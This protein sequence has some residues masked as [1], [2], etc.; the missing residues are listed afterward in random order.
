MALL[1]S[2]CGFHQSPR[3]HQAPSVCQ[4]HRAGT[5]TPT[6]ATD[7]A[8]TSTV[9]EADHETGTRAAAMVS[10]G[11]GT[12]PAA[13]AGGGVTQTPAA[14]M[15]G[16]AGRPAAAR[17]VAAGVRQRRGAGR[18]PGEISGAGQHNRAKPEVSWG[19]R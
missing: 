7:G 10:D 19:T 18:P 16:G 4:G 1:R 17:G 15:A 5:D 14:A 12:A 3:Q 6:T 11:A 8:G 2:P 9:A 13:V